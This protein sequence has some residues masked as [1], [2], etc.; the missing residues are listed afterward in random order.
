[1]WIG[2]VFFNTITAPWNNDLGKGFPQS[3]QD[4]FLAFKVSKNKGHHIHSGS[5]LAT[6]TSP[7]TGMQTLPERNV[8]Q[9]SAELYLPAEAPPTLR[10]A[11]G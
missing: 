7:P 1:M 3:T 8:S 5:S 11:F 2:E 10:V 4:I 6:S 9:F